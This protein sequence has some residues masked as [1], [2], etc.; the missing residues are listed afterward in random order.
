MLFHYFMAMEI[1]ECIKTFNSYY[2]KPL[3]LINIVPF[4]QHLKLD[5]KDLKFIKKAMAVK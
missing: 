3:E 1:N 4:E 5:G 2:E